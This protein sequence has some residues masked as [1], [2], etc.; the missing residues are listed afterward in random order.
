[1]APVPGWPS[2]RGT[3][4]APVEMTGRGLHTGRRC[5]VRLLPAPAGHGIV[6]ARPQAAL[7][8]ALDLRHG[9]PLCTALKS[10]EGVVVRTTEHLLAALRACGIDD[11][12]VELSAEE[13]PILDGSAR[14]WVDAL[15]KAGRDELAAPLRFI[16]VIEEVV[17]EQ[18]PHRLALMP[19]GGTGL[20]L[21]V[22]M[23]MKDVGVWHWQGTLTPAAFRRD[24]AAARSFGQVKLAIPAMLYGLARGI[25]ILRG[26]GP[27][28]AATLVGRRVI[29]GTRMPDEFVRHKIVDMLG[30]FALAGA[31]LLA[32]V[33]ALRPTHD[34]NFGLMRA[35][36]DRPTAWRWAEPDLPA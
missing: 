12:R 34:G 4:A 5:R 20:E 8:A 16:E 23:T 26:A 3:L 35:L 31:P 18:G 29:G 19:N 32:R 13:V 27:W 28:C 30:D 14:P 2:R 21:D 6:F 10:P 1:M 36:M 24:I 22:T 17:W 25:P 15:V 9:Q 7:P 33:Q 11:V